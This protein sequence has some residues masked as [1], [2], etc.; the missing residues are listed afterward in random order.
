MNTFVLPHYIACS[1]RIIM[2]VLELYYGNRIN[3]AG[4]TITLKSKR[5]VYRTVTFKIEFM[6]GADPAKHQVTGEVSTRFLEDALIWL[7]FPKLETWMV[8]GSEKVESDATVDPN[9]NPFRFK[10]V[11]KKGVPIYGT[12]LDDM[13]ML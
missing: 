7:P 3:F 1:E 11:N 5:S 6:V 13:T 9:E 8:D 4:R 10:V 2:T 12:Q